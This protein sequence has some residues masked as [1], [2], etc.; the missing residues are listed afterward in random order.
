MLYSRSLLVIYLYT[1]VCICQSQSPNLSL[2]L[3]HTVLITVAL[4]YILKSN[5]VSLLAFFFTLNSV[6]CSGS[7]ASPYKLWSQSAKINKVIFWGF[8][9]DCIESTDLSWEERT[10]LQTECFNLWI[11]NIYLFSSF[12]HS[13]FYSFPQIDPAH[14]VRFIP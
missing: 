6:G 11:R 4:Q 7:F 9:R 8:Y 14:T 10:F 12:F 2:P 3:H 5:C 13:E 1:V